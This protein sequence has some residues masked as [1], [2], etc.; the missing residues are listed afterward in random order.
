GA[1][2]LYFLAATDV[3]Q[4]VLLQT[5]RELGADLVWCL[6]TVEIESLI[7]VVVGHVLPSG[8]HRRVFL[9]GIYQITGS[10]CSALPNFPDWPST[11]TFALSARDHLPCDTVFLVV[12]RIGRA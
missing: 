1:G 2:D 8:Q 7:K 5:F 4:L 11:R 6:R 10:E 3:V 9:T 12:L